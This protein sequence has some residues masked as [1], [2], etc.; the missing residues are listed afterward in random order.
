MTLPKLALHGLDTVQHGRRV[1]E[2][3][4]NILA[5]DY[6]ESRRT[7][8]AEAAAGLVPLNMSL[9]PGKSSVSRGQLTTYPPGSR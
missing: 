1:A 3:I 2:S 8:V 6:D 5:F 7:Q 9:L 4:N